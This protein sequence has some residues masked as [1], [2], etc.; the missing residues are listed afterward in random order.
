MG[1]SWAV[2]DNWQSV[3][4]GIS[5][6]AA[7]ARYLLVSADYNAIWRCAALASQLFSPHARAL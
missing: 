6:C 7:A 5:V 3:W 2:L 1:I 4:R